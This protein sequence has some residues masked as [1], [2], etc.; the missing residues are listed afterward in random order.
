MAGNRQLAVEQAKK[1]IETWQGQ[2][3]DYENT[4]NVWSHAS[5]TASSQGRDGSAFGA[6]VGQHEK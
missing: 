4:P 6:W 2:Y 3:E 1:L 5:V